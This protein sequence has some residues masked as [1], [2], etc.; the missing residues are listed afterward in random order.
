MEISTVF[1]W[2]G[3]AWCGR[4]S[5]R[6]SLHL[7]QICSKISPTGTGAKL[8]QAFGLSKSACLERHQDG[9]PTAGRP[10]TEEQ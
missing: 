9:R 3:R 7:K 8:K 2:P 4:A 1:G 5:D 10:M 6:S